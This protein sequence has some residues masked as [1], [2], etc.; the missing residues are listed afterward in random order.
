MWVPSAWVR[1]R[2]SSIPKNSCGFSVPL[3][4]L[5]MSWDLRLEAWFVWMWLLICSIKSKTQKGHRNFWVQKICI[6]SQVGEGCGCE[7]VDGLP[8]CKPR[9]HVADVYIWINY[10]SVKSLV[11]TVTRAPASPLRA[12]MFKFSKK[13]LGFKCFSY[14][15][16]IY[17]H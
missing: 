4:L 8:A 9:R 3:I 15:T 12:L 17:L 2:E 13:V 1:E 14:K 16:T 11:F 5:S 6:L 10:L 7:I